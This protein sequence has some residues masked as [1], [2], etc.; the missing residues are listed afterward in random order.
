MGN[1][2][3]ELYINGFKKAGD[4][5]VEHGIVHGEQHIL[6]YPA[7]FL[8]RQYIELQLKEI[9]QNGNRILGVCTHSPLLFPT[10][11]R[12]HKIDAL[13]RECRIILEKIDEDE[14]QRL[15]KDEQHK[16]KNDIDT[17]QTN[18]NEFSLLDPDS[19][20]SR[21]P[22]GKNG[23]PSTLDA[24]LRTINFKSLRDL[25]EKISSLLDGMSVG[26][27]EYQD[28]EH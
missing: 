1:Q 3:W 28:T 13:W 24:K 7:I 14:Y 6:V 20:A 11:S 26:I 10:G 12:G 15:G 18:I 9:I 27:S 16:Y 5:L 25:V 4:L 23:N 2:D 19:Q 22:I 8:Y 17:L 21:Y